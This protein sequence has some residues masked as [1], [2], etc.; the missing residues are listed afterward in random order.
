MKNKVMLDYK[1]ITVI[2]AL[3]VSVYFIKCLKNNYMFA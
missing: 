2:Y 1:N 3:K